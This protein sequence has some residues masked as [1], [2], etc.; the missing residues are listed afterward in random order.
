[1]YHSNEIK[2]KK[3]HLFNLN[4]LAINILFYVFTASQD[5][6]NWKWMQMILQ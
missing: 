2:N 6:Y 3:K 5:Q 4:K 1:M